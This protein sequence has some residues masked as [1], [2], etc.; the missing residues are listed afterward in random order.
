VW[1]IW[2][3]LVVV[4]VAPVTA[5]VEALV[6]SAQVQDCLSLEELNTQLPLA[7]AVLEIQIQQLVEPVQAEAIQYLA[8]L[9]PTV[10]VLVVALVMV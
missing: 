5:A 4:G 2:S 3:W 10:A 6:D 7:L 1:I 9:H 8:R